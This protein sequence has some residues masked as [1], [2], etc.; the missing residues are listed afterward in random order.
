VRE[1]FRLIPG[2]RERDERIAAERERERDGVRE[3]V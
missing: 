2:R 1:I 3:R